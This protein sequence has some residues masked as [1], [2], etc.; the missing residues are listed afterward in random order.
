MIPIA[1]K[2]QMDP[3]QA[4][5]YPLRYPLQY[6]RYPYPMASPAPQ[7]FRVPSEILFEVI[8]RYLKPS[9]T[10]RLMLT[11]RYFLPVLNSDFL[12]ETLYKIQQYI[13]QYFDDRFSLLVQHVA[14]NRTQQVLLYKRLCGLFA[15][16]CIPWKVKE[17]T[18]F[19]LHERLSYRQIKIL[20]NGNILMSDA[21]LRMSMWTPQFKCIATLGILLGYYPPDKDVDMFPL[22]DGR[23]VALARGPTFRLGS[24]CIWS[25]TGNPL[26]AHRFSYISCLV[27]LQDGNLAIGFSLPDYTSLANDDRVLVCSPDFEYITSSK[28]EGCSVTRIAA[29]PNKK[30]V[31]SCKVGCTGPRCEAYQTEDYKRGDA[32]LMIWSYHDG[33][34]VRDATLARYRMDRSITCMAVL[35]HG[36][37]VA[38]YVDGAIIWSPDGIRI[39]NCFS[40]SA[41]ESEEHDRKVSK[42]VSKIVVLTSGNFATVHFSDV[43]IWSPDG[44]LLG[45]AKGHTDKISAIAALLDGGIITASW[46]NTTRVWSPSGIQVATLEN[47]KKPVNCVAALP[48]GDILTVS[49]DGTAS[50]WTLDVESLM[51]ARNSERNGCFS[52]CSVS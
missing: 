13:N 16:R 2:V 43:Y 51:Q 21:Q 29:L 27:G 1:H 9:E 5:Q 47:R 45:I 22:A 15:R 23:L 10:V 52:G 24:V 34:L 49:T 32:F 40:E 31:T 39:N 4:P 46:D 42:K 14:H 44:H 28:L 48:N 25:A 19:P 20:T 7:G 18:C 37:I 41:E 12:W 8:I 17:R 3:I 50:M 30:F 11:C 38:G 6:P 36:N 33:T 26:L 35:P